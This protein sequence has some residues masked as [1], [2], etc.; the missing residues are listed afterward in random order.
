[1]SFSTADL[2]QVLSRSADATAVYSGEDI[3]IEFA[4]NAMLAFWGKDERIIG[5][6]LEEGVPELKGQPFK[7]ML[8]E[9]MRT[10]ITDEGVIPA[11]TPDR[12]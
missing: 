2:L 12:W 6:S 1:M 11:E 8:Q 4:N 10:G 3:V 7:A 9:V 5:Q